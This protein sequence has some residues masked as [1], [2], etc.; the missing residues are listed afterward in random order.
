M[1]SVYDLVYQSPIFESA[2]LAEKLSRPRG[3]SVA[4][5]EMATAVFELPNANAMLIVRG[6]HAY[7]KSLAMTLAYY[8]FSLDLLLK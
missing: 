1:T 3:R 5:N 4:R 6:C 2:S 7:T 8:M